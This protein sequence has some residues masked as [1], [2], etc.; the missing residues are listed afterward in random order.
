MS[1]AADTRLRIM[2]ALE[3]PITVPAY[4]EQVNRALLDAEVYGGEV[5]VT[6]IE[7]YLTQFEAAQ[8][9]LSS[10]SANAALVRADVLE[11]APG[12]R[13]S[14]YQK[15]VQRLRNLLAKVLLLDSLVDSFCNRVRIRRG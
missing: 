2:M 6:Q 5:A 10:D 15:E 3:L 8:A 13:N 14:G 7:G 12:Q 4:V 11:W 1:F 9:S